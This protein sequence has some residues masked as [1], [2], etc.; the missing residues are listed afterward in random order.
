MGMHLSGR[1]GYTITHPNGI[2]NISKFFRP[3]AELESQDIEKILDYLMND[4]KNCVR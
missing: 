1:V 4:G 3:D 2:I